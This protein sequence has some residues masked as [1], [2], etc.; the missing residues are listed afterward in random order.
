M[1]PNFAIMALPYISIVLPA[2]NCSNYIAKAIE[3]VLNQSFTDFE[4]IVINDGS[5][6]DTSAIIHEY[7]D[8]RVKPFD[9][10][11][12]EG[13]VFTLN[14]GITLANGQYIARMDADDIC[15]PNRLQ[16]QKNW[17]DEHTE[18]AVIASTICF[19]NDGGA[20]TGQW[21]K[22]QATTTFSSIKKMMVFQNCIAHPTVMLRSQIAKKYQYNKEQLHCEDYDLWLRL[23]ADGH[24]IEKIP[25]DLLQYRVHPTSVTGTYL[26]KTNPFF[27]QF[28]C[29]KKFLQQRINYARWGKFETLVLAGMLYDG[30]MGTAKSLKSKLGK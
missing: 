17:L 29:K 3:S 23:L 9:N 22:D 5:T 27:K 25:E 11:T 24:R 2:Y 28:Y 20:K 18:T 21:T 8:P 7:D 4:L 13:L 14:R 30:A 16:L 19:I 12:N 26:R 1:E 10:L 6:D 15:M